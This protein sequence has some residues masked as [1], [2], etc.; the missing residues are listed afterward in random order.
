MFLVDSMLDLVVLGAIVVVLLFVLLKGSVSIATGGFLSIAL[1]GTIAATL[2]SLVLSSCAAI[3]L[4]MLA[5]LPSETAVVF[6]R[7]L[8]VALAQPTM[9]GVNILAVLLV[10]GY[11][12]NRVGSLVEDCRVLLESHEVLE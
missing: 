8:L 1:G 4:E 7:G 9:S 2:L 10:L 12:L 6:V 11:G 5:P 3:C